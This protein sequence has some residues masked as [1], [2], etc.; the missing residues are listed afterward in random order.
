MPRNLILRGS[1]ERRAELWSGRRELTVPIAAAIV[2]LQ[3]C[4]SKLGSVSLGRLSHRLSENDVTRFSDRRQAHEA[5]AQ[6]V[7]L[8]KGPA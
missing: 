3:L 6:Q 4:L 1:R 2:L 7:V 8:R 5:R